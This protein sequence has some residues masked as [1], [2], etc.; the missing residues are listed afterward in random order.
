MSFAT[1]KAEAIKVT[2]SEADLS[3]SMNNR[4]GYCIIDQWKVT[5]KKQILKT[6]YWL[7]IVGNLCSFIKRTSNRVIFHI[8]FQ[9]DLHYPMQFLMLE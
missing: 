8:D 1:E 9:L 3:M 5:E 2:E 7:S 4:L 6:C